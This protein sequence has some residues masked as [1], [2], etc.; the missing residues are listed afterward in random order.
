MDATKLGKPPDLGSGSGS[1]LPFPVLLLSGLATV[2]AT[3]V[4]ATSICLHLKNYR[5][6]IL[7]RQVVRIMLMVPIYAI[8]SFISLFSLQAAFFIDVVRDIY[9]FFML[10]LD[11]RRVWTVER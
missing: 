5:K 6:P 4:S 10:G 9:E 2:A 11:V 7:Q 8:A 1:S 3:A